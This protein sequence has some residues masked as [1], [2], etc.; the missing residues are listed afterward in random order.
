MAVILDSID[1]ASDPA[2]RA[3]VTDAFFET[4]DRDSVLGSYSIDELGETTLDRMTG[5]E[6]DGGRAR[7]VARL[8]GSG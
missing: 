2:D 4:A 6:L 8:E 1:R 3:A 5:Y 7:P